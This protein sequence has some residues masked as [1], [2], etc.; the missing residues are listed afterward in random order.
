MSTDNS[1]RRQQPRRQICLPV[2][3]VFLGQRSAVGARPSASFRAA[4]VAPASG[5]FPVAARVESAPASSEPAKPAPP[6]SAEEVQHHALAIDVSTFGLQIDVSV[7]AARRFR[8]DSEMLPRIEVRFVNEELRQYGPR[9][10]RVRWSSLHGREGLR[11][12]VQFDAP[13]GADALRTIVRA[14]QPDPQQG[15]SLRYGVVGVVPAVLA[16]AL[17]YQAYRSE[18]AVHEQALSQATDSAERARAELTACS[19]QRAAERPQAPVDGGV[20]PPVSA[21]QVV[22][23]ALPGEDLVRSLVARAFQQPDAAGET[24]GDE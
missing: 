16:S 8:E 14:G 5:G 20:D 17:W 22:D 23:A 4:D 15:R 3:I 12:G 21:R 18:S 13:L 6:S 7:H 1:E 9:A 2:R 24:P 11:F 10:S 19:A